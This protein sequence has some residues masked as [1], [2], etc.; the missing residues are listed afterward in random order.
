MKG[1]RRMAKTKRVNKTIVT[2]S[3]QSTVKEY[4]DQ[5]AERTGCNLEQAEMSF[6]MALE[7]SGMMEQAEQAAQY[8]LNES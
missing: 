8:L 6:K 4:L 1:D 3:L 2:H 5:I 7:L